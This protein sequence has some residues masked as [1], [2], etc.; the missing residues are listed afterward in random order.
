MLRP[1]VAPLPLGA[2]PFRAN[3]FLRGVGSSSGPRTMT[4]RDLAEGAK[5]VVRRSRAWF[6]E[7][8][9]MKRAARLQKRCVEC[10]VS[11]PS[12][13]SPYCSRR[14]Q[15]RFAG[16]YFWDAAR[17][18]VIRRDRFTCRHCG[19]RF[20]V[21]DLEVDHI[22][23]VSRGGNPLD[24]ANLQTLCK[25]CHRRKTGRFLAVRATERRSGR[26]SAAPAWVRRAPLTDD[27]D[28]FPA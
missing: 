12:R 22:V 8:A 15:W 16:H 27:L 25:P 21:R 26:G 10:G 1:G 2:L 9:R 18:S 19:V 23:E 7:G 5:R 11:L 24:E 3:A 28:W 14:C 13:R 17:A 20:R 4:D 6:A